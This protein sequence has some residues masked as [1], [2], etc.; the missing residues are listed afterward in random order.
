VRVKNAIADS[1]ESDYY[2]HCPLADGISSRDIPLWVAK[3]ILRVA[4]LPFLG[5]RKLIVVSIL[6]VL[7]CHASSHTCNVDSAPQN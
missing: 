3:H 1:A 2:W 6:M 5:Q 7:T 4:T